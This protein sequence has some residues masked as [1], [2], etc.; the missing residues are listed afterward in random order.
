MSFQSTFLLCK[1]CDEPYECKDY[2]NLKWC[3]PCHINYLQ[4]KFTTSG[5][6]KIDN[7]IQE[8]QLKINHYND[9]I[10]ELVSYNQF[11]DIKEINDDGL[12][13]IYSA[14]W[15]DGPLYYNIY[16]GYTRE[17]N[18]RFYLKCLYNS[19]NITDE[20]LYEV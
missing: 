8:M 1:K 7:L 3:K 4:N 16:R 5:N 15:K 6:E 10:L 20:F 14:I 11:Y 12:V 13:K 2:A 18:K 9:I 17:Q 19:Q